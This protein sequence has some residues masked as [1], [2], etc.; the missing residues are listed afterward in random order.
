MQHI[1]TWHFFIPVCEDLIMSCNMK[2]NV[3]DNE[4]M[5]N[6]G[7]T[8]VL[9]EWSGW[10]GVGDDLR[11]Y[12]IVVVLSQLILDVHIYTCRYLYV[13]FFSFLLLH[14]GGGCHSTE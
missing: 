14:T 4:C 1:A 2:T 13:L 8:S 6:L 3:L 11:L 10:R 7:P 5:K 12:M 9:V